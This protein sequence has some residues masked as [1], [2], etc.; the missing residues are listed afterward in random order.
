MVFFSFTSQDTYMHSWGSIFVQDVLMPVRASLGKEPLSPKAHINLLRGS[1][2]F[3]AVFA[4]FFSLFYKQTTEIFMFFAVTGAIWAGGAGSVIIGGL[5]WKRGTTAAAYSALIV[6]SVT[7]LW[8]LFANQVWQSLYGRVFPING[9]VLWFLAMVSAIVVYVVVSLITGRP[10]TDVNMEKLL[11]RGKYA[12]LTA[13]PA[14]RK[15]SRSWLL[16]LVGIRSEYTFTDKILAYVLVA[17][18]FGWLA[19]FIAATVLN[20]TI[21]MND[22][23]W[24]SLWHF[25]IVTLFCI[26]IPATAWFI[27]GGI[28]DIR[29]LFK[30]LTTAVR[31]HTDDGRVVH[32][33]YQASADAKERETR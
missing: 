18:N 22:A 2:I 25:Y 32:A 8:G 23:Q 7:G 31:D 13:A 26:A 12:V 19:A 21:G 9:Q 6:G 17:W 10:A 30:T 3:V 1:I 5:Y 11:H 28:H 27:V 15:T 20:Y 33:Q 29:E 16:D 14:S 4:F 24:G